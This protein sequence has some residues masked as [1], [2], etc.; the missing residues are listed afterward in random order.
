VGVER[1]RPTAEVIETAR[2]TLEPPRAE[3]TAE[4]APLMDDTDLHR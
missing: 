1:E 4:M 3:H 2:F